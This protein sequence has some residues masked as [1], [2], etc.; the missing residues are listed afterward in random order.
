MKPNSEIGTYVLAG[1]K[2]LIAYTS[3]GKV[4]LNLGKWSG[5]FDVKYIDIKNG[6][7]VKTTKNI[8]AGKTIDLTFP[9]GAGIVWLT[10]TK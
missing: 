1:D 4:T 6:N 8:K 3:E 2:A 9:G 5:R 7:V 10:R